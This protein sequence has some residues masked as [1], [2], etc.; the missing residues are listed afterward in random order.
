MLG[1]VSLF[2]EIKYW[3]TGY[4]GTGKIIQKTKR[5]GQGEL[6]ATEKT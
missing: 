3:G 2:T 1:K 6:V 5:N 4:T